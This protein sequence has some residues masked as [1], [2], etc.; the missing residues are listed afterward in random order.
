MNPGRLRHRV[1]LQSR[2]ASSGGMGQRSGSFKNILP[3]WSEIKPKDSETKHEASAEISEVSHTVKIR[4]RE[5]VLSGMRFKR[6]VRV[7]D[8]VAPPVDRY[9]NQRYLLCDCVESV[10][11]DR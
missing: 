6:G 3:L 4:Y 8:I 1:V 11:G 10:D 7:F 9:E 5:G 2:G